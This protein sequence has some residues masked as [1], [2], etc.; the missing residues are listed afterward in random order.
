[1]A[2]VGTKAFLADEGSKGLPQHFRRGPVGP[3]DVE[4]LI[5][6]GDGVVDRVERLLPLLFRI[7][8]LRQQLIALGSIPDDAGEDAGLLFAGNGKR[9]LQGKGLAVF[10]APLGLKRFPDG[11][12]LFPGSQTGSTGPGAQG[13]LSRRK[14]L[15]NWSGSALSRL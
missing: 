12:P 13:W 8:D 2:M 4:I 6:N 14:R 3:D 9:Y 11:A 1:M 5:M 10:S 7:S 15:A